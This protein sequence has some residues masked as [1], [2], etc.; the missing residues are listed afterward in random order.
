MPGRWRWPSCRSGSCPIASSGTRGATPSLPCSGL[1]PCCWRSPHLDARL[2]SKRF[3]S[4]LAQPLER[5]PHLVDQNRGAGSSSWLWTLRPGGSPAAFASLLRPARF[6]PPEVLAF[7]GLFVAVLTAGG[8]WMTLLLRQT[9]AAFWLTLLIP[10]A[11]IT[12]Y[13][14]IG[15]ADWM[16]CTA[17]GLY[18]VAAFFLARRQFLR[19]QDTAWTGGVLS[20]G[21]GRAAAERIRPAGAQALGGFV[22]EG[23]AIAAG[24]AGGNGLPVGAASGS[25]GRCARPAPMFSARRR[26]WR[27]RC[28]A[29]S[30]WLC[31]CWRAAKAWPT[32]ANSAP[33]TH[34]CACPFRAALQFAVKL[35]FVLVLGG[36]LSAAL[37][38]AVEGVGSAM[39]VGC[40]D[41]I[42]TPSMGRDWT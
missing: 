17:L 39:G 12:V 10:M 2:A 9:V 40:L 42:G 41:A 16:I 25:C 29:C 4:S 1:G 28:L 14:V 38:C 6:V 15:G 34:F 36:L 22:A 5:A 31:R 3:L 21:R 37:L 24:H 33:W 20:F 11:T 13:A 18:A 35:I 19:L 26:Y 27:W 7:S 32:S 23:T 8:L 30:G